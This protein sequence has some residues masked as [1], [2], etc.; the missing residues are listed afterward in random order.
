MASVLVID[1]DADIRSL[2]RM[3]LQLDG[4]SV[5]I[6]ANG[7]EGLTRLREARLAGDSPVVVLDVQMPDMDGWQVLEAIRGDELVRDSAV[8]LCTV[9]AGTADL[10]RGWELGCDAYQSK[11]FDINAV[12]QNVAELESLPVDERWRLRRERSN[13]ASG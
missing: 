4:H 6:A 13:G 7:A 11:P 12:S 3:A 10:A 1:D 8:M 5:R 2:L 9:K